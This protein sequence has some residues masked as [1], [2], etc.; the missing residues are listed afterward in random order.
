VAKIYLNIEADDLG[1]LI[2]TLAGLKYSV[3]HE[4]PD[5][6]AEQPPAGATQ[7]VEPG[8]RK[9]RGRPPKSALTAENDSASSDSVTSA[10]GGS[11]EAKSSPDPFGDQIREVTMSSAATPEPAGEVT[12]PMV[13]AALAAVV[14]KGASPPRLKDEVFAK[15]GS[16][17]IGS[18]D[19]AKYGELL[20]LLNEYQP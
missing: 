9:R 11:V 6:E 5:E 14:E 17:S 7:D 19:P 20:Q 18:T 2:A 8:E 13:R 12:L 4:A 1:D 3:S 15:V 10:S 16:Q